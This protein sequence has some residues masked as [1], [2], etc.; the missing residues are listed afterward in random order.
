MWNI[1]N[2]YRILVF[3]M[4]NG[5]KLLKCDVHCDNR[6]AQK[7]WKWNEE[8]NQKHNTVMKNKQMF[9]SAPECFSNV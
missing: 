4:H 5:F 1:L 2:L 6:V 9:S 3:K 8:I 7:E